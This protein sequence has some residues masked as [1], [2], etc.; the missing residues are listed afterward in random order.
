MAENDVTT[1]FFANSQA[2]EA[3]I[4]RLEKKY[5]DLENS[6]KQVSRRSKSDA[7]DASADLK[8]WAAT[9]ATVGLGY[10]ALSGFISQAAASQREF[11]REAQTTVRSVDE[12]I[13]KLRVQADMNAIQGA[14]TQSALAAIA[15]KNATDLPTAMAASEELISQGFDVKSGTGGAVDRLLASMKG[16]NAKADQI[17]ELAGAYGAFLAATGQEK[18]TENLEKLTRMIQPVFNTA[19]LQP[20]DIPE[21]APK[22]QALSAVMT[23]EEIIGQFT[24]MKEKSNAEVGSTALKIFW[25]KLQTAAGN[26]ESIRA[27]GEMGLK[28]ADVDVL[29]ETPSQILDRLAEGLQRVPAERQPIVMNQLFDERATS[30]AMGLIRDREKAAQYQALA[31]GAT[32]EQFTEAVRRRTAGP[33]AAKARADEADRQFQLRRAEDYE[34]WSNAA[35]GI[36][37]QPGVQQGRWAGASQWMLETGIGFRGL[38]QSP[39]EAALAGSGLADTDLRSLGMAPEVAKYASG[40][41]YLRAKY[42][43]QQGYIPGGVSAEEFLRVATADLGSQD[44]PSQVLQQRIGAIS[45]S[46]RSDNPALGEILEATKEQTAV[47]KEFLRNVDRKPQRNPGGE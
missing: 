30:A 22:V 5:G 39:E 24:V 1:T 8:Q 32:E 45:E 44:N 6:M 10:S 25:S 46:Q 20:S 19:A 11:Q 3:A 38:F 28:P 21:L 16:T 27:L 9:L 37:Q 31:E 47:L 33:A 14:G 2:A 18:N 35:K 41:D 36:F 40:R 42:L 17:K 23:P 13:R 34:G 12:M 29:G 15:V 26:E 43:E 4:A 7:S